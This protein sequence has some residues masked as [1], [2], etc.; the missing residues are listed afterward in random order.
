LRKIS[1]Q[2]GWSAVRT[3]KEFH[4]LR[5][6]ND[7]F[8][9]ADFLFQ[10]IAK[11]LEPKNQVLPFL[12]GLGFKGFLEWRIDIDGEVPS[13]RRSANDGRPFPLGGAFFC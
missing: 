2:I 6:H 5:R 11:R 7:G 1:H 8:V 4:F 13:A 3:K 12:L 9:L 10:S